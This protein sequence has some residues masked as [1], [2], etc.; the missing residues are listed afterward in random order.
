MSKKRKIQRWY[1]LVVIAIAIAMGAGASIPV[2]AD[3]VC[4]FDTSK[5]KVNLNIKNG[6]AI[7]QAHVRTDDSDSNITGTLVLSRLTNSGAVVVG[8]WSISSN[9]RLFDM[10]KTVNVSRG[11]YRLVLSAT[12]TCNGKRDPI[13]RTAYAD[14]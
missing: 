10:K 13:M 6:V 3:T 5:A 14:Y 12:V 7:C 8:S 2:K 1:V 9:A 11:D 4:S